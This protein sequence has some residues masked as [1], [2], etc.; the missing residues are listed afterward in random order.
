MKQKIYS[1]FSFLKISKCF[2]FLLLAFYN[3]NSYSQSNIS[4]YIPINDGLQN[5]Q[6]VFL[7]QFN[8]D[9]PSSKKDSKI[10]ATI[11][12]DENGFFNLNKTLSEKQELYFIYLNNHNTANQIISQDFILSNND[13]IFFQKSDMP[14]SIFKN[15]NQIDLEWQKLKNFKNQLN[16]SISNQKKYLN[17]IRIY[18]KDSLQILAVKLFSIKELNNKKLLDK[19][20]LL[21]TSYYINLLEEL[22]SSD[23]NHD[24]YIFLENKLAVQT[25]KMSL[26]KYAVSKWINIVLVCLVLSLLFYIYSLKRIKKVATINNLSKQEINI[27]NYILQGKSN[28]EIADEL[29]ISLSTVKTHITN[30]YN[31]LNVSNR[32]ELLLKS[33]NSTSTST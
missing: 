20:I 25:L 4:G 21:N 18:S 19:D 27:K 30:I 9:K 7:A 12:I 29:F 24:E 15:T 23:I 28:K 14:F 1:Q 31:K 16:A 8:R 5:Q 6:S 26:K 33:K 17:E 13:S 22:K 2:I 10:I 32:G 11:P 3:S